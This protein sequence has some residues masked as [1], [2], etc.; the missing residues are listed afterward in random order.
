MVKIWSGG[1]SEEGQRDL[2]DIMTDDDA[3]ID[4]MLL[5]YEVISLLAY[6]LQLRN[7]SKISLEWNLS[8]SI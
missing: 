4:S 6:H 3:Q 7:E 2:S 1:A 5:D 8:C